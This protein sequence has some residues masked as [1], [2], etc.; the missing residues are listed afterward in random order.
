MPRQ[1]SYPTSG[2]L[3]GEV[4]S[5][6]IRLLLFDVLA[7]DYRLAVGLYDAITS[8]RLATVDPNGVPLPDI[9]LILPDEI[10]VSGK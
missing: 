10:K 1:G 8:D 9:R 6:T 2:W 5:E 7:G 4:V 3:A